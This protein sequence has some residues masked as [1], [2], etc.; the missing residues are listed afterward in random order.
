M[1]IH[2]YNRDPDEDETTAFP[3]SATE[4]GNEVLRRIRHLPF[5]K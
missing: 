5:Q 2:I 4:D 1:I 3:P